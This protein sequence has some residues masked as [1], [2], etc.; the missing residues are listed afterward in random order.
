M[1]GKKQFDSGQWWKWSMKNRYYQNAY[2][3][4]Y[5][6]DLKAT[7]GRIVEQRII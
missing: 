6:G 4:A 1:L 3:L 2:A 5:L 7:E